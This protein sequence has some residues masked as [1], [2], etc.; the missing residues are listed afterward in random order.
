MLL[1][2]TLGTPRNFGVCRKWPAGPSAPCS[3]PSRLAP[4]GRSSFLRAAARG[5]AKR[6][7]LRMTPRDTEAC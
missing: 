2:Q 1:A 3:R 7:L 6:P 5:S 4:P